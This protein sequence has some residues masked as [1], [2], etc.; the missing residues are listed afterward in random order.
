MENKLNT[1]ALLRACADTI[2]VLREE[3]GNEKLTAQM[4]VTYLAVAVRKEVP[5]N[6]LPKLARTSGSAMSRNVWNIL[7]PGTPKEP[8]PNLIVAEADPYDRKRKLVQLTPRGKAVADK[9]VDR[10]KRY[11][12]IAA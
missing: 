4:L 9:I 5:L 11:V 8:G 2:N 12:A 7:G 10:V 1:T 3:T 6:E